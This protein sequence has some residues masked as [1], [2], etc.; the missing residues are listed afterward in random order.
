MLLIWSMNPRRDHF[1]SGGP[2]AIS[3]ETKPDVDDRVLACLIAAHNELMC[4]G[5]LAETGITDVDLD[6]ASKNL[7][8]ALEAGWITESEKRL[9]EGEATEEDLIETGYSPDEVR[10]IL[11]EQRDR[12]C[13]SST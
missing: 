6:G 3:P 1:S 8:E 12:A 4:P 11:A 9:Y 5:Y 2:I 10:E 13:A 7:A